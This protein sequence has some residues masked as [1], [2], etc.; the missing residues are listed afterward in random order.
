MSNDKN[1][2]NKPNSEQKISDELART[3]SKLNAAKS[4]GKRKN[5][6]GRVNPI[7]ILVTLVVGGIILAALSSTGITTQKLT[8]GELVAGL[9]N[10]EYSELLVQD[11]GLIVARGKEFY[12][13]PT[14]NFSLKTSDKN[15]IK[16]AKNNDV[17]E[18]SF[19]EIDY[20]FE[21]ANLTD[22]IR[23]LF[24]ND[25]ERVEDILYIDGQVLV[26]TNQGYPD[27]LIKDTSKQDFEEIL[28]DNEINLSA[29]GIMPKDAR[30]YAKELSD[31]SINARVSSGSIDHITYLG[32]IVI[33]GRT[34]TSIEQKEVSWSPAIFTFSEFLQRE[35]FPISSDE[36]TFIVDTRTISSGIDFNTILN[37]V[38]I[39]AFIFLGFVIF[40]SAQASGMGIMQF[41]QSKAKMFFGKKTGV[42][43]KDVAGIDEAREELNEIVDFL[44]NPN[45]YRKLGARIPKGILM[46][47]PP[48]TG[49]T[50]LARAIAGEAGVPF[51][52][53]SGSEFEE[54]LVGAGASRVRDLFAKAKKAAPALIFIDEIDAVARKRGTRIQSGST[55]QTLN[56][57][58]VE[59]DGFETNANIIVIAAT[60]RPDVL[61]RAILRPGRFDRQVRIEAPDKEGRIEILKIHSKNKPLAANV[62]LEKVAK[63]TVGF[64]GA[65][66]ENIM[67]EAAIIAAKDNRKEITNADIDD[68]VSK[69]VLGPAKKSRKRTEEELNLVA[70]HEAGHAL[71]AKMTEG[72][73]PVDKI[74]IVSRGSAGGVT[75]FL[76]EKDE[77][78]ISMKRL[79]A[80]I[81]VS[82]GGRAAEEVVL[83]DIS[84]GAS[85]DIEQATRTA[86]SMIQKYGMSKALGL[87]QYGQSRDSEYL[88][89]HY[90]DAQD[91]SE[92]TAKMIDNEV[93][94][95][96]EKEYKEALEI[97]KNNR[98]K[99]DELAKALRDK[100][101]LE[102][103]EFEK[104]FE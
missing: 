81:R 100:E 96:V 61:D 47:G 9:Q 103:D 67:N 93:R 65:D 45:K 55:E 80:D 104:L 32:D 94:Q 2:T 85:N 5:I 60:N 12:I 102:K 72:S 15:S 8:L 99:L 52:H 76:P 44:K 1:N 53:T 90:G 50:L 46:F 62:D 17:K 79:M 63:R 91:Y 19:T 42:T 18:V 34:N 56:Q 36:S 27:Y 3:I 39:G 16:I 92:E 49:K 29:L 58:L 11:D 78:I 7:I 68:A 48:G 101:V 30:I 77:N 25:K 87:V 66:L 82:L 20:L 38:T 43:F 88:G 24:Q 14:E 73:V 71:V 95:L 21:N 28:T 35:G 22:Q 6:F 64:T 51:F 84:T 37:V 4:R 69:V 41:G 40:R 89:Y 83:H 26:F 10:N 75:M 13:A 54:M 23:S 74:S 98:T 31:S 97:I 57:I 86:R 33:F 59:M 70:Y